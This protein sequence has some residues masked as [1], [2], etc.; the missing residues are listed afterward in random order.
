VIKGKVKFKKQLFSAGVYIDPNFAKHSLFYW[1]LDLLTYRNH[2][3][4]SDSKQQFSAPAQVVS[5]S[6]A[7]A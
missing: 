2:Y 3:P 1:S 7:I 5:P 6:P 4:F